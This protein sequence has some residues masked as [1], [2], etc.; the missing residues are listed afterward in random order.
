MQF[1]QAH[2]T[3]PNFKREKMHFHQI[4]WKISMQFPDEPTVSALYTLVSIKLRVSPTEV[5]L[6][7]LIFSERNCRNL[8]YSEFGKIFCLSHDYS[9]LTESP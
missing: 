4:N 7:N 9:F 5:F 1:G 3:Q 2:V 8:I 6:V